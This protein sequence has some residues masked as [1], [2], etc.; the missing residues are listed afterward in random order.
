MLHAEGGLTCA[1]NTTIFPDTVAAVPDIVHWAIG[2]PDRVHVLTLICVRMAHPDD[3]YDY[4]VGDRR[5]DFGDTPYVSGERYAHLTTADLYRQVRKVLPDFEFAAYLGGTA[6]PE[7]LK[8]VVGCHLASAE[9]SYGHMG[10]RA[11]EVLQNGNHALKG[12]YLAF[13]PPRSSRSGRL[14]LIG[15]GLLDRGVRR[16]AGRYLR[17]VLRRPA[18]LRRRVHIQALSVVQPVDVLPTGETD[19]CDG[20]PNRT[21]WNDRLVPACRA[22]EYRSYGGPVRLVPRGVAV[23][24][25]GRR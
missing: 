13:A 24:E 16:A 15:L 22:E 25:P 23:S 17:A 20:C 14:A 9:R 5:I 10:A 1:F 21:F 18:E 12:R 19:T 11:F 7:S 6:R 2:R 3:P 8:W 4:W